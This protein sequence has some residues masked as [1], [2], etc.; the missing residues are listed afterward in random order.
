[1]AIIYAIDLAIKYGIIYASLKSCIILI[2]CEE[3]NALLSNKTSRFQP[4]VLLKY[5]SFSSLN[6]VIE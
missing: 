4:V 5:P 3:T 6:Q 1:M 2:L